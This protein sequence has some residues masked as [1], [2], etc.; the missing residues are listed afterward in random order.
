MPVL[1]L[2]RFFKTEQITIELLIVIPGF[3]L[4][5]TSVVLAVLNFVRL[6]LISQI[7]MNY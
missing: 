1:H 5:Y 2:P 4:W 3:L 7:V 6:V